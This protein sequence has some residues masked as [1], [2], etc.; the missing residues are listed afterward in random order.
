M[1]PVLLLVLPVLLLVL[2]GLVGGQQQALMDYLERR[3]Q[4]I[5]ERISLWHE[6]TTRYASELREAKQALVLQLEGLEKSKEVQ[7]GELDG[8]GTRVSRVEREMDFLETQKEA[9]P[10]VDV[11]EKL[12]E[13]Q[14]TV[15]KEK[16]KLKYAKLSGCKDMLESVKGMKILKRFGDSEG[17]WGRDM[18]LGAG[19]VYIFNGSSD[20]T[21]YQFPSLRDFTSSSGTTLGTPIRLP[22]QWRGMGHVVYRSHAYL[23]EEGAEPRLLKVSLP[24]G[25]LADSSVLPLVELLPPYTLTPDTLLDLAVDE[26]GLWAIYATRTD[27][28]HVALAKMDADTLAVSHTWSTPCARENAEAAFVVCGTLYV[29][30]NTRLPGRSRVQCVYDVGEL[31]AADEAPLTYFPRRQGAHSSLKYSP[32]EK[33]LYAWGQGYQILYKLTMRSKLDI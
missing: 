14:V 31:L 8:L 17:V 19:R 1:R 28:R 11:D 6:Q 10:C 24:G 3:L 32:H 22:G 20:D 25:A 12:V 21:L 18:S 33:L 26:E 5:E 27:P 23:L 16:T 2:L 30:Y 29:V 15:A 4:A 13:Q 7:R 9:Q